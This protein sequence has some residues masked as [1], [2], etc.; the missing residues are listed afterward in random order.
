MLKSGSTKAE[1]KFQSFHPEWGLWLAIAERAF[2]LLAQR[3]GRGKEQIKPLFSGSVVKVALSC[4]TLCDPMHY[5]VHGIL[6]A[7]WGAR[8]HAWKRKAHQ[9]RIGLRENANYVS[10]RREV[11]PLLH[12]MQRFVWVREDFLMLCH[13]PHLFLLPPCYPCPP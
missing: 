9:N 10:A 4:P 5:I 7:R 8:S 1:R 2:G 11:L 3:G 12:V 6:E 13:H